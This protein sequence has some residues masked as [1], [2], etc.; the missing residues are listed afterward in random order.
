M[1][2]TAEHRSRKEGESIKIG[3][4]R[5]RLIVP[6]EATAAIHTNQE[7]RETHD[8]AGGRRMNMGLPVAVTRSLAEELRSGP[9]T[10]ASAED[11]DQEELDE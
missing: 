9:G 8:D 1:H 6:K 5:G 7:E 2:S 11:Q 4:H 3:D 10:T